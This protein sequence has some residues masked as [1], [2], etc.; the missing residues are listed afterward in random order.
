MTF[1]RVATGAMREEDPAHHLLHPSPSLG[2]FAQQAC[3]EEYRQGEGRCREGGTMR[4][5]LFRGVRK[6]HSKEA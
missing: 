3:S 5:V 2:A 1:S 4:Y 6:A